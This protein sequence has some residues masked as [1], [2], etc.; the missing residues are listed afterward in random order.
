MHKPDMR[1]ET[2]L[3]QGQRCEGSAPGFYCQTWVICIL[4]NWE[5]IALHQVTGRQHG[6]LPLAT[7]Q[8]KKTRFGILLR[9]KYKK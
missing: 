3:H 1:L 5:A 7:S 9:E 6:K 8:E 4:G 2:P